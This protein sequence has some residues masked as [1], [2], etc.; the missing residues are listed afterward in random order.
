MKMK[1]SLCL[2]LISTMTLLALSSVAS[3]SQS[4][5]VQ[6]LNPA[7]S[8]QRLKEFFENIGPVVKAEVTRDPETGKSRRFGRVTVYYNIILLNRLTNNR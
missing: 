3:S 1:L 7:T 4:V 5:F 2:I 8:D 6:N